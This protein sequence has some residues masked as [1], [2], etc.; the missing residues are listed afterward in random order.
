MERP[1]SFG[2]WLQQRRQALGLT[3]AQ[4]AQRA[5]CS[6]SA[7]RKIESGE[8]RPSLQIAELLANSLELA[9]QARPFFL[10]AARGEP[11]LDRLPLAAPGRPAPQPVP[12][13]G[14][15]RL[16]LPV[17][18]APL[19]GRLAELAEIGRLLADPRCR[20]L[21]LA[22]PGGAGKTRLA[23][24]AA[25]RHGAAFRDGAAFAGL[26]PVTSAAFVLPVIAEAVGF[27]FSGPAEPTAQLFGFLRDRE[28]LLVVDNLEHLLPGGA[29]ELLAELLLAA[30]AVKLLVT[31]REVLNVQAEWVLDILGLPVAGSAAEGQAGDSSA[32]ELFLQRARR[33]DAAFAP[34]EE[35]AA[36]ITRICRLVEG[37]PLAIE[38]AAAWVRTLTCAEIAREIELN[39]ARLA[40]SVRDVPARHRALSAVFEHSWALLL[41]EEQVALMRLSVFRGGFR[42]DAAG[43]VAGASL[44]VLSALMAKSLAR[45]VAGGRYDLHEL[46]RQFARQQLRQAGA[47]AAARQAQADW[48]LAFALAAAPALYTSAA[49]AW[50]D[51]L[52]LEH[53]NLREALDWALEPA[54]GDD[55]ARRVGLG[56][57]LMAALA[58]FFFV[59]GRHHEGLAYFEQLLARPESAGY[60]QARL[61]C[62]T[63]QV[64]FCF[65]NGRLP[66]AHA[67]LDAAFELN[68][69]LGDREQMARGLEFRGQ[70][71]S[72]E[73]DLPAA[74]A[75]L[76]GS[77]ALWRE[78]KAGF[79]QAEVL[80]H[81]GDIALAQN[82]YDLAERLYRQA[83][84]PGE[85]M[86]RDVHHPYPR[87]RLA[88]LLLRRGDYAG[89]I[90][91]ASESLRLNLAIRDRRAVAACLA[92]LASIALA[93]GQPGR[94]ARLCGAAEAALHSI[95]AALMPPDQV[96]YDRTVAALRAGPGQHE[97][98]AAWAA[99]RGLTLAQA[100]EEALQPG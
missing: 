23:I 27:S 29:A 43:A 83:A 8:R 62:L 92:A 75:A 67:A 94:A 42:R 17:H 70:L 13:P 30:P 25:R 12:A 14:A 36:A 63:Q 98:Q 69:T 31:S 88:Y 57:A 55:G 50:L 39:P 73:G 19:V 1:V 58:D 28:L 6:V 72:T 80:S 5:G 22:G 51:D 34:G 37:L 45:R 68:R 99:G 9:L 60:P 59:H 93:Q 89:A 53:H 82:D 38:L 4:L 81:L 33:A 44:E 32:V 84:D 90:E 49:S 16:N 56:L 35:D 74:R 91:Q 47:E 15:P 71:A 79:Q 11:G 86:P 20:L 24:A 46:V 52:E 10:K 87:R 85:D 66:E 100:A 76:H 65:L 18:A 78:L 26:A 54:G 77:L 41:P 48:C 3:R 21:T 61:A 96:E 40:V 2:E 64:Y 7:L 97:M 95:G